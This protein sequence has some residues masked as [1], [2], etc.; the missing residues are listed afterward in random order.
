MSKK[1]A[2]SKA[3]PIGKDLKAI[4]LYNVI[5]IGSMALFAVLG[6][7]VAAAASGSL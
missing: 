1:P 3:G 4:V 5:A 2:V 6:L 7:S